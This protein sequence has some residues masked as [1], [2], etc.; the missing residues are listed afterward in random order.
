HFSSPRKLVHVAIHDHGTFNSR[1]IRVPVANGPGGSS[2]VW[3]LHTE[4][5][6]ERGS[7]G[8]RSIRKPDFSQHKPDSVQVIHDYFGKHQRILW[9]HIPIGVDQCNYQR[10]Y[11]S[12]LELALML[13]CSNKRD[14]GFWRN[15]HAVNKHLYILEHSPRY[16]YS[17]SYWHKRFDNAFCRP[18]YHSSR[19]C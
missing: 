16:L 9:N 3:R 10:H 1:N 11:V 2:V 6:G 8:L 13:L 5:S 15:S 4:R 14:L 12:V 19:L 18:V 7:T 17:N